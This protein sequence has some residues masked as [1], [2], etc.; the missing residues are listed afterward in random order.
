MNSCKL[1]TCSFSFLS[2]W[3]LL[4]LW[5][6]LCVLILIWNINSE[7]WRMY[8]YGILFGY[9]NYITLLYDIH[10][11]QFLHIL[12]SNS[13]LFCNVICRYVVIRQEQSLKV[14]CIF[15][16]WW[17]EWKPDCEPI[18]KKNKHNEVLWILIN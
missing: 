18:L 3:M 10:V 16:Q 9:F 4:N 6:I 8:T 2:I 7:M 1:E 5:C 15:T 17:N 11:L 13:V 12:I 14:I